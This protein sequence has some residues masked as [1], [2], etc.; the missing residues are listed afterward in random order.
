MQ[1]VRMQTKLSHLKAA[2]AAN[3]W[4]RALAI[5]ARFQDLGDASADIKRAHECLTG[6]GGFYSQI[7]MNPE[8]LVA[9]GVEALKRR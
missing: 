6:R 3:D 2:A 8:A 7:G 9:A 5:A 1:R 4:R